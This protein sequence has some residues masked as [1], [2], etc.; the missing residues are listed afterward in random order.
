M[1]EIQKALTHSYSQTCIIEN[2]W[3]IGFCMCMYSS[4]TWVSS[5][6]FLQRLH[7]NNRSMICWICNSK[8]QYE[9]PSTKLLTRLHIEALTSTF[10]R[11]VTELRV[12]CDSVKVDL[13]RHG[14][15]AL[16]GMCRSVVL[17]TLAHLTGMFGKE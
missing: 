13:G 8:P 14:R 12:P 2:L 11:T 1:G 16:G 10:I 6:L 3:Q 15:T 17:S 4:E 7:H 5:V 9:T